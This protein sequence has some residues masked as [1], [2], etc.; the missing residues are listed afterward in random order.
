MMKT[1]VRA[2]YSNG[3]L[4]PESALDIADGDEVT[5]TVETATPVREGIERESR[6]M[7]AEERTQKLMEIGK[8]CARLLKDGPSAVEHG[9]W[10]YD[11]NGL[12]R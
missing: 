4:M 6:T 2:T 5:L 12:P 9:D 10:L 8:R 11:E 3:T 1:T 7:T